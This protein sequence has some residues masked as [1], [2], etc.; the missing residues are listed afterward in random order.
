MQTTKQTIAGN[1]NQNII[2]IELNLKR[3][4]KWCLLELSCKTLDHRNYNK[5]NKNKSRLIELYI[6]NN[7]NMDIAIEKVCK[8]LLTS[9]EINLISEIENIKLQFAILDK[10]K[11]ED[12]GNEEEEDEHY[13]HRLDLFTDAIN[14]IGLYEINSLHGDVRDNF[15]DKFE[16]ILG[17]L[18]N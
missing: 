2:E 10:G 8:K 11:G 1:N 15:Q 13:E 5:S 12:D 18:D 4:V 9:K 7:E 16:K 17:I 14:Y 6:S 3:F